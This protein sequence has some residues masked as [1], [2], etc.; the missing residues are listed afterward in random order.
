MDATANNVGMPGFGSGSVAS[1]QPGSQPSAAPRPRKSVL[2]D[3][4]IRRRSHR[5][6][7]PLSGIA[8]NSV[9]G[10][11][12]AD[13]V[14]AYL[15]QLGQPSD[16]RIQAQAI[17]CAELAV[18][19]EVTRTAAL[20]NGMPDVNLLDQVIRL[21]AAAGRA[22]RKLGL[23]T[24]PKKSGGSSLGDLLRDD[25]AAQAARS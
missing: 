1:K 5:T 21:E 23:D 12:V 7:N 25:L 15:R 17:A 8:S 18:L 22:Q 19:A 13:L 2:D 14:R 10:R 9:Q 6:N 3:P 24:P 11:R 20:A 16:V 4:P